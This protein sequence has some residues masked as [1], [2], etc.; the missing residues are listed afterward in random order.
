MISPKTYPL[1]MVHPTDNRR[2]TDRR[3]L[4]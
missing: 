1:T 4:P 3:T 2:T